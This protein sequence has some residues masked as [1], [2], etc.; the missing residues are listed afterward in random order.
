MTSKLQ[1]VISVTTAVLLAVPTASYAAPGDL[2]NTFTADNTTFGRIDLQA[3]ANS[4]LASVISA[5]SDETTGLDDET[6]PA[7]YIIGSTA[8]DISIQGVEENGSLKLWKV[9]VTSGATTTYKDADRRLIDVNGTK[10][11]A[12][13]AELDKLDRIVIAWQAQN[14][15]TSTSTASFTFPY[16]GRERLVANTDGSKYISSD[17]VF[18]SGRFP[19]YDLK[20]ASIVS[21]DL[22]GANNIYVGGNQASNLGGW[23]SM[24][25]PAGGLPFN[26]FGTSGIKKLPDFEIYD[27]VDSG[28]VGVIVLGLDKSV[29][30]M[31]IIKLNSTGN[32]VAFPNGSLFIDLNSPSATY[33]AKSVVKDGDGIIVGLHGNGDAIVRNYNE[34]GDFLYETVLSAINTA[35]PTIKVANINIEDFKDGGS[36]SYIVAAYQTTA[37]VR[38][39]VLDR[40]TGIRIGDPAFDAQTQLAADGPNKALRSFGTSGYLSISQPSSR[41]DTLK[42]LTIDRNG[43][44]LLGLQSNNGTDTKFAAV[45]IQMYDVPTTPTLDTANTYAQPGQLVINHAA[46]TTP[47]TRNEPPTL[48]YKAVCTLL[49]TG[50]TIVAR[51]D[52]NPTIVSQSDDETLAV[53]NGNSYR[54]KVAYVN[55]AGESNLSNNSEVVT[56]VSV[57]DPAKDLV[58]TGGASSLILEYK[59]P[60]SDGGLPIIGYEG[61]CFGTRNGVTKSFSSS[62]ATTS[63]VVKAAYADGS[64]LHSC[65]VKAYNEAGFGEPSD[66]VTGKTDPKPA[67]PKVISVESLPNSLAVKFNPNIKK[68]P[69]T[70]APSSYRVTCAPGTGAPATATSKTV[71]GTGPDVS[72]VTLT[73]L[74]LLNNAAYNCTVIAISSQGESPVSTALTGTPSGYPAV[75]TITSIATGT[76]ASSMLVKVKPVTPL[77]E[78]SPADELSVTCVPEGS[79]STLSLRQNANALNEVTFTFSNVDPKLSYT[80]SAVAFAKV[81][82]AQGQD[83]STAKAPLASAPS[84]TSSYKTGVSPD[85]APSNVLP[86]TGSTLESISLAFTPVTTAG[87]SYRAECSSGAIKRTA[88]GNASPLV[89]NNID[90]LLTYTCVVIAVGTGGESPASLSV[91]HRTGSKAATPVFTATASAKNTI[92][93]KF[94][95]DTT[96]TLKSTYS[97]VCSAGKEEATGSSATNEVQVKVTYA[98]NYTCVA[99]ATNAIGTSDTSTPSVGVDV[100]GELVQPETPKLSVLAGRL[101]MTTN[102]VYAATQ[103]RWDCDGPDSFTERTPVPNFTTLTVLTSGIYSCKVLAA[104]GTNLSKQSASTTLFVPQV[105]TTVSKPEKGVVTVSVPEVSTALSYTFTCEGPIKVSKTVIDPSAD[106]K[107]GAGAYSC[108]ATWKTLKGESAPSAAGTITIQPAAPK[109]SYVKGK[110][111]VKLAYSLPS[112]MEWRAVCTSSA[113]KSYRAKGVK[114]TA[115]VRYPGKGTSCLVEA[116]GQKS[117]ATKLVIIPAKKPAPSPTPTPTDPNAP[118]S[119]TTPTNPNPTPSPTP[120]QPAPSSPTLTKL[121]IGQTAK[122]KVGGTELTLTANPF[123]PTATSDSSTVLPKAGNKYAAVQLTILNSGSTAWSGAP[124]FSTTLTDSNGKKYLFSLGTTTAGKAFPQIVNIKAGD[125]TKGYITFEVPTTAKIVNIQFAEIAGTPLVEWGVNG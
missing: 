50:Q 55:K 83:P 7:H 41:T 68:D 98:G 40:E 72:S 85:G 80:C 38:L 34:D 32:Q 15:N 13:D 27:L 81:P 102:S 57:P 2:D 104:A 51:S 119:P 8:G 54:C 113:K 78:N 3:L 58:V 67:A 24:I 35:N 120:T 125:T 25:D 5:E 36:A 96:T 117:K 116:A 100:D 86:S 115:T 44:L 77:S 19:F 10:D 47:A 89:I 59:R 110:V 43:K 37:G 31:K 53:K 26:S 60:D 106:L 79:S 69:D 94:T 30:K 95:P 123:V 103:Y 82:L 21:L 33:Q 17:P 73:V 18:N 108:S 107:L 99:T 45:R 56:P 71:T 22:D 4:T 14:K 49:S 1:R 101:T 6:T 29:N 63:M 28:D 62:S 76:T 75:P 91:T 42:S 118:S 12:I 23:V 111:S 87:V 93:L 11:E 122:V 112:S 16:V 64:T 105:N 66:V 61:T 84:K 114:T 88:E 20:N 92:T 109:V 65:S 124:G 9:P 48:Y 70:V 121:Q 74:G 46:G 52:T 97:A 39:A 90:P